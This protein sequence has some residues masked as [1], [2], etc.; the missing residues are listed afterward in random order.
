MYAH[1]S[2]KVIKMAF[3]GLIHY[4]YGNGSGKASIALGHII[5]GLGHDFP[6]YHDSIS[7]KTRSG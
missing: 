4:Y 7:K 5:R 3:E 1:T 6:P 2:Q